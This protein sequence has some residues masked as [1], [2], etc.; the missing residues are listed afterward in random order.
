MSSAIHPEDPRP[1]TSILTDDFHVPICLDTTSEFFQVLTAPY[2]PPTE[3]PPLH[4][5]QPRSDHVK[6]CR[7]T[8]NWTSSVPA[9]KPSSPSHASA[10]SQPPPSQ[11]DQPI[12]KPHGRWAWTHGLPF[13]DPTQLLSL[14]KGAQCSATID[15]GTVGDKEIKYICRK[16]R[17]SKQKGVV[18]LLLRGKSPPLLFHAELALYKSEQY[19]RPLQGDVVPHI[20]GVHVMP[21]AVSITMEMPHSSFWIEASPSMPDALKERVIAA[22]EKIHAQGVLHGDP[23][24]RHMLIGADGEVMIIDFGM[25]RAV[26]EHPSVDIERAEPEEFRLE[27]RKVKYKL[28][29]MGA[30]KREGDMVDDYLRRVRK[31][32]K[33]S[34]LWKRRAK[35]ERVGPIPQYEE[36]PEDYELDPPVNAQDFQED[37]ITASDDSPMR[38]IVP[39]Q[40]PRQ[41]ADQVQALLWKLEEMKLHPR[42]T[43]PGCSHTTD[44]NQP[45]LC[46][47]H[48]SR[49]LKK[50]QPRHFSAL[51]SPSHRC[52]DDL[53]PLSAGHIEGTS[54]RRD[55]IRHKHLKNTYISSLSSNPNATATFPSSIDVPERPRSL[56]PEEYRRIQESR[57]QAMLQYSRAPKGIL[58]RRRDDDEVV[59]AN[60]QVVGG[61]NSPCKKLRFSEQ[62]VV[63]SFRGRTPFPDSTNGRRPRVGVYSRA[64]KRLMVRSARPELVDFTLPS[65]RTLSTLVGSLMPWVH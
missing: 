53:I 25:S 34:E 52:E 39:G 24:L 7:A 2:H 58:K 27:M 54:M 57:R 38:V 11:L 23:E 21:E 6:R 32:R 51:N 4:R 17:M 5:A 8:I 33:S 12:Y 62:S 30:R 47:A 15:S 60:K 50:R 64:Y 1:S 42:H 13:D 65:L 16:W 48:T 49:Y 14:R 41:V 18:W 46:R 26:R 20:I 36:D 61:A 10:S 43:R 19:L 44:E 56:K 59:D 63:T 28:D 31:N 22:F 9:E 40:T 45:R 3:V 29:Y 35:G 37:W 55:Y